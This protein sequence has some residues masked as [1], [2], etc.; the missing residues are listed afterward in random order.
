M[1]RFTLA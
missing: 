1:K